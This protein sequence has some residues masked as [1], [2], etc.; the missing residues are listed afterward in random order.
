MLKILTNLDV[1]FIPQDMLD[2]L[3]VFEKLGWP[4]C[5]NLIEV[6]GTAYV[7]RSSW[8]PNLQH[9]G[10]CFCTNDDVTLIADSDEFDINPGDTL[11]ILNGHGSDAIGTLLVFDARYQV[12]TTVDS[13]TRYYGVV[14]VNTG[15]VLSTHKDAIMA[16]HTATAL[17]TNHGNY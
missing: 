11:L 6:A 3:S 12:M 2:L 17:N 7:Q 1:R 9:L 5:R 14:D 16:H 8:F 13:R 10:C 4:E 15:E